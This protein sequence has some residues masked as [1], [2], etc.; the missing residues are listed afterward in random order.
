MSIFKNIRVIFRQYGPVRLRKIHH[1]FPWIIRLMLIGT[2]GTLERIFFGRS[3]RRQTVDKA[4]V[5]IIGHWRSG[6]TCLHQLL[7]SN[8]QW[9][10]LTFLHAGFPESFLLMSRIF[11]PLLKMIT[12]IF[13]ARIP[14]F[15]N[16]PFSWDF[17]CEEDTSLVSS[18]STASPYWAYIFPER[19]GEAFDRTLFH[20]DQEMIQNWKKDYDHLIRKLSFHHRGKQLILKSPANMVRIQAL[21][22]MYPAA[23]FIFIHRKPE[24]ILRSHKKLWQSNMR[25]FALSGPPLPSLEDLIAE[26]YEKMISSYEQQK[27]GLNSGQLLEVDYSELKLRPEETVRKIFSRLQ[28]GGFGEFRP[29]LRAR[30]KATA[31]YTPFRYLKFPEL[32]VSPTTVRNP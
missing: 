31:G 20:P 15:N 30:I 5:F 25:Q 17:P 32:P 29:L 8:P 16:I 23:K 28:M 10:T 2:A 18:L 26:T 12:G 13:G 22:E 24:E 21:L 11:K 19:A 6:T 4:P 3:I 1:I 14:Y 9:G 7:A 27:S